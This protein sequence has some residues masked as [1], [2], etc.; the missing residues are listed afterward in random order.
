MFFQIE[1]SCP[2]LTEIFRFCS[3]FRMMWYAE[4]R[5]IL[6]SSASSSVITGQ[7]SSITRPTSELV[8]GYTQ[9]EAGR[10]EFR[11]PNLTLPLLTFLHQS[12]TCYEAQTSVSSIVT[13]FCDEY[14][15]LSYPHCRRKLW[16]TQIYVFFNV[17]VCLVWVQ[18][19]KML[20]R[21]GNQRLIAA[22]VRVSDP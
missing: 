3:T 1:V 22:S 12:G 14:L 4:L 6:N 11:P 10:R 7:F 8:S 15:Q 9:C 19:M 20:D 16:Q 5:F 18:G 17:F 21:W 2:H 13:W